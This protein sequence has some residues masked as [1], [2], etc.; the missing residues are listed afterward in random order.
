MIE[1]ADGQK[2]AVLVPVVVEPIEVELAVGTVPVEVDHIAVAVPVDPRGAVKKYKI[3]SISLPLEYSRGCIL[4]EN[5]ISLIPY[6][7]FIILEYGNSTLNKAVTLFTLTYCYIQIS[8]AQS[9]SRGQK[10]LLSK[11]YYI[12][13]R[14]PPHGQANAGVKEVAIFCS[15][16]RRACTFLLHFRGPTEKEHNQGAGGSS[17]TAWSVPAIDAAQAERCASR[18]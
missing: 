16:W 3:P 2:A 4:F 17:T 12:I 6:T 15:E 5:F 14:R 8:I 18:R 1:L 9:R 7:K 11:D 13:K 10:H